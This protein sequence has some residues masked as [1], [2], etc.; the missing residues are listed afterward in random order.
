MPGEL[1]MPALINLRFHLYKCKGNRHLVIVLEGPVTY[2]TIFIYIFS[3]P[4]T[5]PGV[6]DYW[7]PGNFLTVHNPTADMGAWAQE[8]DLVFRDVAQV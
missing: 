7:N 2:M 1:V 6:Q 4:V 3:K 8:G 5:V